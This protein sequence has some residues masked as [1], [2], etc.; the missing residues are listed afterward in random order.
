MLTVESLLAELDLKLAAGQESADRQIRWV[1]ITEIEDPTPWL[2]GGELLLTTGFPLETADRQRD[3]VRL[4]SEHGLAGMGLGTGFG[5][6]RLPRA[7]VSEAEQ[8]DFPLFEVPYE[9]PFIAITEKAFTRLVNE[10]YD[11]LE[12]G[13]ELHERLER[14]VIEERG[15]AEIL[16]S[17]AEAIGGSALIF[18]GRGRV[19]AR[20]RGSG[21]ARGTVTKLGKEVAARASRR[22]AGP[23]APREDDLAARAL[24]LPVPARGQGLPRAWLT[25]ICDPGPLGEFERLCARQAAV[26]VALELMRERTVRETERRLAGDVLAEALSGRLEPDEIRGRLRPFGVGDRATVLVFDLDD[27]AAAE[28][29]LEATLTDTAGGALVA[30]AR[31]PRRELLCAVVDAGAGDPLEVARRAKSALEAEHGDARAAT[32]RSAPVESLRR[33]FHEARCALE[34]TSLNDGDTPDVASHEDLGAFTLLLSLQD[35]E[36]LRSYSDEL[37]SP[38]EADGQYGDELLRSLEA[39]IEQNGQWERAA[40]ELYCHRHTLRYRIRRVEELTGRDLGRA[41]DRIELWLAL[42]ARE[43][44]R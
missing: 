3:F 19:I 2:A 25:V 5:H 4:L 21:P 17:V 40:R 11:A 1:H 12:R 23:F 44:V 31:T 6:Q 41:H 37:L 34:A 28:A 27:P 32:S 30:A 16:G 38:I 8:L 26:V 18:D 24:A 9:M 22:R 43:L 14:L 39:F 13:T 36:A 33:S 42:R 10:Q 29:T 35:D 20:S 15:V 7:L